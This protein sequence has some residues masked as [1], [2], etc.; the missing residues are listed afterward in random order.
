M[1]VT[2]HLLEF[3]N[4]DNS[5]LGNVSIE[6]GVLGVGDP[7]LQIPDGLNPDLW[8]KH[9]KDGNAA[10]CDTG[11]DGTFGIIIR[12]SEDSL[13]LL[14]EEGEKISSLS[15]PILINVPSGKIIVA[16][17]CDLE[18]QVS[19]IQYSIDPGIYECMIHMCDNEPKEFLGFVIVLKKSE[20]T[21]ARNDKV[22]E[23]EQ[24]G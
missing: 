10:C 3:K 20:A 23:I 13:D 4:M 14:P 2:S 16:D 19:N 1:A 21:E 12:T 17:M 5:V 22:W 15:S 11:G 8:L 18:P 6:S 7:T 24:L 9:I